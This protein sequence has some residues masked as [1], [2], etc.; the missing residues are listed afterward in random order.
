[1]VWVF[2]SDHSTPGVITCER[3]SAPAF[4]QPFKD[5][6]SPAK[7]REFLGSKRIEMG[8]EIGDTHL[9]SFL[10]QAIAF[11]SG[12]N[13]HAARI[14]GIHGDFNQ[15]AADQAGHDTAHGRRLDL[16]GGGQLAQSLGT[17]ENQHGERREACRTF[18]GGDILFADA[19]EQVDGGGVQAVSNREKLGMGRGLWLGHRDSR[20]QISLDES[21]E[22]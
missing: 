20:R 14:A 10:Q 17:P 12:A 1:M 7:G 19:A 13:V 18:T 22:I 3:K 6:H 15:A 9:A 4:E 2:S 8:G 11:G 16:L 5:F 21:S